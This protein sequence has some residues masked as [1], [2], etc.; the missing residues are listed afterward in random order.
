MDSP[1][2]EANAKRLRLTLMRSAL[3]YT[4]RHKDTVRSLGLRR[5]HQVV[6]LNDSPNI[7]G[8]IAK[9]AH[10]VKVEEI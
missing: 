1:K 8:M 10:L 4:K 5:L 3:G 9:V 7:R 2:P 6:E